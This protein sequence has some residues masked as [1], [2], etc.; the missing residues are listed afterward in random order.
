[1]PGEP[2]ILRQNTVK[3][4]MTADE[5]LSGLAA[6]YLQHR[7][8]LLRF[9]T[10]R[11]G[12]SA[13]AEDVLQQMWLRLDRAT[14]GPIGNGRA[15]LY[16]MAQNIVINRLR[17]RQRR[18]ARDDAWHGEAYGAA[19]DAGDAADTRRDAEAQL[20]EREQVALLASAIANLP[21]G[22]RRAFRLHKIDGLS[23]AETAERLGISRSGV[24]KHIAVAMRHLRQ[25]LKD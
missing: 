24:E 19:G 16:R 8:E 11:T 18:I 20:I 9:L 5:P 22:A 21:D 6:L 13:E 12:N 7:R 23:H 15:Y 25:A 2:A 14:D 3:A 4:R 1:M 10:A 17:E